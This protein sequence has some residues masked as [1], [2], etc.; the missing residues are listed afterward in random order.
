[1]ELVRADKQFCT[2][3]ATPPLTRRERRASIQGAVPTFLQFICNKCKA[4]SNVQTFERTPE[5]ERRDSVTE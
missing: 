5:G 4:L 3:T 2:L 1:M